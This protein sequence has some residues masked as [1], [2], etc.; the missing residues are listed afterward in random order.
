MFPLTPIVR[1]MNMI[2]FFVR[3]YQEQN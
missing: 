1:R 3:L 2:S